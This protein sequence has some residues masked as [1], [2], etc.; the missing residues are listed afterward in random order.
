MTDVQKIADHR[1]GDTWDGMVLLISKGTI[2]DGVEELTPMDITGYTALARFKTSREANVSFEFKTED[3]TITIPNGVDGKLFFKER[4]MDVKA[5]N[6]VC[7]V[8]LT[9]PEG[10]VHTVADCEWRIYPDVS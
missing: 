7:D 1:R 9:S 3:K 10:K 6:Y 8:Q 4:K 2:V 5:G